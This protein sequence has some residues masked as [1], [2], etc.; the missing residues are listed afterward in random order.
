MIYERR[1][2]EVVSFDTL[3]DAGYD[4]DDGSPGKS[5]WIGEIRMEDILAPLGPRQ[6]QGVLLYAG[7]LVGRTVREK[8]GIKHN[9][10]LCQ[11]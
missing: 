7:G 2:V 10:R 4:I 6:R 9:E 5:A 8:T 1:R 3:V 11:L